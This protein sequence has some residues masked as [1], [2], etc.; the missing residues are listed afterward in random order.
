MSPT[1][2]ASPTPT[3]TSSVT[4]SFTATPA[5]GQAAAEWESTD[6]LVY[7]LLNQDTSTLYVS[8]NYTQIGS[9]VNTDLG[10]MNSRTGIASG[11]WLPMIDNGAVYSV[12]IYGN[13]LYAVGNFSSVNGGVARSG[14]AAFDKYTGVVTPWNPAFNGFPLCLTISSGVIY[15]GGTFTTA[16]SGVSRHGLAAVDTVTGTLTT[17]DPQLQI[18]DYVEAI[19]LASSNIYVGGSITSANAGATTRHDAAAFTA[20]GAV[21]S[22]NPAPNGLVQALCVNSRG[23]MY[24]GGS[25][26]A[27]G[28]S[29]RLRMAEVDLT[30]GLPTSWNPGVGS[31][32]GADYVDSIF[33]YA[34]AVYVGGSFSVVKYGTV[35]SSNMAAFNFPAGNA[36]AWFPNP[37]NLV[38]VVDGANALI[39]VGGDFSAAGGLSKQG[40]A[41][42]VPVTT[43]MATPNLTPTFTSTITRTRTVTPTFTQTMTFTQTKTF[44]ASP[45]RTVTPT[46]TPTT[47]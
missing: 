46:P 34:G 15:I 11:A 25:F 43:A 12:G 36:Y 10:V 5:T 33:E 30:Y 44:T 40:L 7:D 32:S 27:I 37:N 42:I 26:S 4:Q 28:A 17:W 3:G 29:A 23:T 35:G 45:T 21:T 9:I 41:A 38:R 8:G 24:M 22:W 19:A 47:P 14:A 31:G 13:T 2:T 1:K 20:S 39:L 16:N 6:G 18:G